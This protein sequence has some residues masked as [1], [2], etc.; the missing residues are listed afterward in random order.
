MS[1]LQGD[2]AG[3]TTQAMTGTIRNYPC[4][5]GLL[6]FGASDQDD[7]GRCDDGCVL[8]DHQLGCAWAGHVPT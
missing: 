4:G 7:R 6:C 3:K 1:L 8:L 5:Q 2:I